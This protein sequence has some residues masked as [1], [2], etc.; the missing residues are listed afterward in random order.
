MKRCFEDKIN[1]E[2]KI[3]EQVKRVQSPE[4][5]IKWSDM[6]DD[7]PPE[8]PPEEE[9]EVRIALPKPIKRVFLP[10]YN[11]FA[12]TQEQILQKDA[13]F[14]LRNK[15]KAFDVMDFQKCCKMACPSWL[16]D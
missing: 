3:Q 1:Y 8:S 10:K 15:P 4:Y 13:K 5:V 6:I 14:E 16:K 12:F 9:I 7:K 2:K 11:V